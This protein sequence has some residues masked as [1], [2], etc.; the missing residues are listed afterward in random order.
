[1]A[2]KYT[3]DTNIVTAYL[4]GD[5]RLMN[6]LGSADE[7]LLPFAVLGELFLG[8][9]GSSNPSETERRVR[10]FAAECRI[11]LPNAQVCRRYAEI[12]YQLKLAGTP[13]PENDVWIGACALAE[14]TPLVTRDSHFK[15]I[16][17]L[18]IKTW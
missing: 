17:G 10:E 9:V 1:M 3:L 4:S 7:L 18:T 13:V 2:G 6:R 11:V 8:A 14:K 15:A 5:R 16:D 12:K